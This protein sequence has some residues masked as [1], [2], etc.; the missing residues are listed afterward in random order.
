[1]N[2]NELT[3]LNLNTYI[4]FLQAQVRER[5]ELINE[6]TELSSEWKAMALDYQKLTLEAQEIMNSKPTNCGT[7]NGTTGG[8]CE[9]CFAW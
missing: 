3:I 8:T 5:D 4:E 7:C 9:E 2:N 1:M 6:L